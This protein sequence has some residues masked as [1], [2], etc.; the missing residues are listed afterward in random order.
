MN[1]IIR[2][3]EKI[4]YHTDL[5]AV[6]EPLKE[7]LTSYNWLLSDLEYLSNWG[8]EL[9][10]NI[11]DDFFILNADQLL[12]LED[13]QIVWGVILGIPVEAAIVVESLPYADGNEEV[14]KN[15]NIQHPHAE[16]EIDC[17]DSGYTILKFTNPELSQKFKDGFSEAIALEKF[18]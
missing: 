5:R 11:H 8:K 14:W 15:G 2:R 17:F 12:Q 6:L 7:H 16:I 1:W 3:S 4:R 9:P 10:I 18:R 13:I